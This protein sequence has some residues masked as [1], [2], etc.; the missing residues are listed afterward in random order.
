M[1]WTKAGVDVDEKDPRVTMEATEHMAQ[2]LYKKSELSDS[3]TFAITLTNDLGSDS[4]NVRLRVGR[5]FCC[6]VIRYVE[7]ISHSGRNLVI[8]RLSI[9]H[10][11]PKVHC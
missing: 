10:R 3:G 9:V 7:G 6:Q 4:C 2:L 8:F 1:T 5:F 11:H